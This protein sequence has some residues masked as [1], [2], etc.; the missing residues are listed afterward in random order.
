MVCNDCARGCGGAVAGC[1]CECH[2]MNSDAQPILEAIKDFRTL[3][4]HISHLENNNATAAG[5]RAKKARK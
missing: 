2:P 3:E 1:W 5:V 4:A